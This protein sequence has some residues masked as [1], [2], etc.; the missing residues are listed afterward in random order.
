M[1]VLVPG[2]TEKGANFTSVQKMD[3]TE[4]ERSYGAESL[5]VCVVYNHN[6]QDLPLPPTAGDAPPR[7]TCT[8]HPTMLMH[9]L[10]KYYDSQPQGKSFEI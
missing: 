3:F 6:R 4:T 1:L 5:Q 10:G 2:R 9:K 8:G 7:N